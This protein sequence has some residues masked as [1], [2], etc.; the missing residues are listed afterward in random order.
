MST[1]KY[2]KDMIKPLKAEWYEWHRH[3]AD[4]PALPSDE[5]LQLM[6]EVAYH[7]SFTVDEQRRTRFRLVLCD[8]GQASRS[9][10]IAPQRDLVPHEIM[11]LAPVAAATNSM[12]AVA[13]M[14]GVPRIWGLCDLAFMQLVIYARGPGMLHVGRNG[15]AFVALEGGRF[16]DAYSK[17]GVFQA[18]ID[19]LADANAALW[20]DIQSS[21][22]SWS[23]Q[24]TVFPGHL[25][26]AI[27][28]IRIGGHGGTVLMVP[29]EDRA[30]RSLAN[31][32]H[33]KYQCGDHSIWPM[34]E[35][36][37]RQYDD[38]GREDS[39]RDGSYAP[40]AAE[41]EVRALMT[42]IA[43]LAAVDGAVLITDRLRILGFGVEVLAQTAITSVDLADGTS[44]ELTAYGTRHRSAFRFCAAYPRGTAFVCSQDGGIKVVRNQGGRVRLW[45]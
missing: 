1:Y 37:V 21:G 41:V 40:E 27:E 11:R 14:D 7:A 44:R 30:S 24:D 12:L 34:L 33:I 42:R 26:D 20:K 19:S 15:H 36:E 35:V 43:G 9:L 6:L 28:E 3:E 2:P 45:Q 4:P 29:D 31:I 8:E 17:P 22:R 39:A 18:V 5:Q 13:I 10:R 16:S 25:Y 38:E 23:P 32:M